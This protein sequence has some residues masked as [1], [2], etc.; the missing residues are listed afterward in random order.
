MNI[1]RNYE[2]NQVPELVEMNLTSLPDLPEQPSTSKTSRKLQLLE[3]EHFRN[4]IKHVFSMPEA[5][6]RSPDLRMKLRG[7]NFA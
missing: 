6:T 1:A 7:G 2:V 5:G 3:T 4:L